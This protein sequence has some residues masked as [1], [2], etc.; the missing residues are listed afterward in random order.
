M[1]L[2]SVRAAPTA[3][4]TQNSLPINVCGWDATRDCCRLRDRELNDL[5]LAQIAEDVG[6]RNKPTLKPFCAS[7]P[8]KSLNTVSA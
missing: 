5:D 4:R 1:S 6:Q 3:R 8:G 2:S 7:T